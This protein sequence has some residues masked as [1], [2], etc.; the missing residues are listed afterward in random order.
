MNPNHP[1]HQA[2]NDNRS[3]QLNAEDPK[4]GGKPETMPSKAE[5]K[6]DAPKKDK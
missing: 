2:N 4:F 5:T 1:S 6:S 3:R